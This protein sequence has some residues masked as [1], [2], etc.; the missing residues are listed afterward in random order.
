LACPLFVSGA[1]RADRT[2]SHRSPRDGCPAGVVAGPAHECCSRQSRPSPLCAGE[3]AAARALRPAPRAPSPAP[4]AASAGAH[5]PPRSAH[6]HR[7]GRQR[8]PPCPRPW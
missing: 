1:S 8:S 6:G 2:Q 3:R 5:P 7:P 4:A